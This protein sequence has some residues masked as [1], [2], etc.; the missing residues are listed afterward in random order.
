MEFPGRPMFRDHGGMEKDIVLLHGGPG[1]PGEMAPVARMLSSEWG[2]IEHLQSSDTIDGQVE[3]LKGIVQSHMKAPCIII[4]WSWGAWLGIIFSARYPELAAKL[5]LIGC[6]PLDEVYTVKMLETRLE[7]LDPGERRELMVTLGSMSD[8]SSMEKD[9]LLKKLGDL[10]M[11][12]DSFDIVP[13]DDEVLEYGF[14]IFDRV[15]REAGSMRRSGELLRLCELVECPISVIHGDHDPHPF[16]GVK[17]PLSRVKD[18]VRFHLLDRC[19]HY[20]W[21]ERH[22]KDEFFMLLEREIRG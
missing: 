11:V 14:D 9:G 2:V 7:R 6:G 3:E 15:S 5:I 17:E 4:G 16:E 22:A 10:V 18:K 20:P 1:A 21:Y 19:G 8:P 13:H 12:S